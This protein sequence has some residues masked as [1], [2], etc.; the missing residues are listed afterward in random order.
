MQLIR[1]VNQSGHFQISPRERTDLRSGWTRVKTAGRISSCFIRV[2]NYPS[3]IKSCAD[4]ISYRTL[5]KI[6]C[7][8][9]F[10]DINGL[11]F[12]MYYA[13]IIRALYRS[14]EKN[15]PSPSVQGTELYST[16]TCSSLVLRSYMCVYIRRRFSITLSVQ[17]EMGS[18]TGKFESYI[19]V[20]SNLLRRDFWI[21]LYLIF[22]FTRL[23]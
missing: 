17:V 7:S 4:S 8:L 13:Q 22:K 9:P 11:C 16:L 6:P 21:F 2:L 20:G 15:A 18:S 19:R 1:L 3:Y 12:V 5:N 10:R 23:P 14:N